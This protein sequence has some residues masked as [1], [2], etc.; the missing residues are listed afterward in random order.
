MRKAFRASAR[1]GREPDRQASAQLERAKKSGDDQGHKG[2]WEQ[3][4]ETYRRSLE[5]S[6][7]CYGT[8]RRKAT[9]GWGAERHLL[10]RKGY[11][12]LGG[13]WIVAQL[14]I[15]HFLGHIQQQLAI[16]IVRFAQ[17]ATKLVEVAGLFSRAPP[18]DVVRGLALGEVR[19]LRGLLAIV[20]ELIKWAFES[21]RQLLQRLDR[22]NSVAILDTRDVAAEQTGTLL[23]ITLG[24]FLFFAQGAKT[25]ADNHG[26]S[27]P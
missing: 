26:L 2:E 25:I 27:I 1:S 16:F 13:I 20:E 7:D 21:T 19:E 6:K 10:R 9:H 4:R 17:Q 5:E 15:G 18:G 8:A 23:D 11:I 3:Q 12:Y 22:G 14:P 24:E